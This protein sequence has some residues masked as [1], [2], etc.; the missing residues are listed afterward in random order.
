MNEWFYVMIVGLAMD[1]IGVWMLVGPLLNVNLRHKSSLEKNTQDAIKEYERVKEQKPSKPDSEMAMW[2][3]VARLEAIIYQLHLSLL[4]EKIT[5]RET[6]IRALIII[7]VG[8]ML[9]II[10]N[11]IQAFY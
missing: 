3:G 1:I 6:A 8:F 7:T 5:H 10:A 9:Q 11:M 4:K 2:S